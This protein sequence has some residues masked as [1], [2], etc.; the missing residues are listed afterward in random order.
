MDV[1]ENYGYLNLKFE[2]VVVWSAF[3]PRKSVQSVSFRNFDVTQPLTLN[4]FRRLVN[5]ENLVYR[6]FLFDI[7]AELLF[8]LTATAD[9]MSWKRFLY[10]I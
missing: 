8:C 3:A 2:Q 5:F 10:E 9:S 6:V 1:S 7:S 4:L